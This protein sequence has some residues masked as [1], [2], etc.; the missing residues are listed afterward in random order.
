L[1]QEPFCVHMFR[2]WH[3][4]CHL[5]EASSPLL[6]TQRLLA[7]RESC[8]EPLRAPDVDIDQAHSIRLVPCSLARIRVASRSTMASRRVPFENPLRHCFHPCSLSC[9]GAWIRGGCSIDFFGLIR[10]R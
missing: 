2:Q 6:P 9:V 8:L 10:D 1:Q 3:A 7:L 5:Q 4:V